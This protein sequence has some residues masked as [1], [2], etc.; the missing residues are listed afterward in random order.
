MLEESMD[1]AT[2]KHVDVT[3]VH[4]LDKNMENIIE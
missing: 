3:S 1:D 2:I 4:A